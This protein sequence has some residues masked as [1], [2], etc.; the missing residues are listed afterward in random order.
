M[1][2]T[3]QKIQEISDILRELI[4]EVAGLKERVMELERHLNISRP[5]P[6]VR[7]PIELEAESYENIGGIYNEGYHI[8][9]VA[10]GQVRD[11]GDC[12]FCVNIL[13]RK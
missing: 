9:P 11:E 6:P 4:R 12:L 3:T 13:E 1:H 8:C 7:A 2:E 10:F 5:P